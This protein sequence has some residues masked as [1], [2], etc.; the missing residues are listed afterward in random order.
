VVSDCIFCRIISGEIPSNNVYSD[1][2]VFAFRD[3]NPQAPTHVL[4]LPKRHI[5]S[6]RDLNASE[7]AVLGQ[8]FEA[9]NR[10]AEQEGIQERG[11]RTV[12]NYGVESGHTV[13]HLHIH[14]LG[15]ANLGGFGVPGRS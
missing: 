9:A 14:L 6:I 15:G 12:I 3:I 8:L 2:N 1:E 10:I 5:P 7:G 13:W 4:I 11:F